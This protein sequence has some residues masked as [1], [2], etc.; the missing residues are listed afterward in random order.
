MHLTLLSLICIATFVRCDDEWPL[1]TVVWLRSDSGGTMVQDK[2]YGECIAASAL[3]FYVSKG[4]KIAHYT[5]YDG[6]YS[7]LLA[8][9]WQPVPVSRH[10]IIVTSDS[11]R[12][13]GIGMLLK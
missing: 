5:H 6:R 8:A 13:V 12:G 9:P 10:P 7:W 2:L 11:P 3:N 1:D 4:Y